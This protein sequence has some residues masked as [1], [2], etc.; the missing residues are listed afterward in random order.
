MATGSFFIPRIQVFSHWS[1]CGQTLPQI[2]GIVFFSLIFSRASLNLFSFI[3]SINPLISIS[4]GQPSVHL[5]FLHIRHLSLSSN[6]WAS[7]K[8]SSTSLKFFILD[9]GL[10][11][12]ILFRGI[13]F[14]AGFIF[15]F[16][17]HVSP[18]T[19]H[20]THFLHHSIY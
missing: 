1:S 9:A 18:C 14:L 4:T 16:C 8:P 12:A 19:S 13:F 20:L 5:G 17:I 10:C 15:S 11:S 7:E 2:P 6:A 3:S